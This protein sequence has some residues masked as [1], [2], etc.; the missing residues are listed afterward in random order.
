MFLP[1]LSIPRSNSV[2]FFATEIKPIE[3]VG[4]YGQ[5]NEREADMMDNWRKIFEFTHQI[6]KNESLGIE[7]CPKCFFNL[8]MLGEDSQ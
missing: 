2:T 3:F 5:G 4:A 6:P 7:I 1:D 8:V